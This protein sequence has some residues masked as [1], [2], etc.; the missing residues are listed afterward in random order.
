MDGWEAYPSGGVP[1]GH[2]EVQ[3]GR[4]RGLDRAPRDAGDARRADDLGAGPP[5]APETTDDPT[6]K[7]LQRP[8]ERAKREFSWG[9]GV[10]TLPRVFRTQISR[11]SAS[12]LAIPRVRA[13]IRARS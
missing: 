8:L 6:Q 3:H 9:S 7:S 1:W 12:N 5:G 10:I 2:R 4:G 11:S 13:W